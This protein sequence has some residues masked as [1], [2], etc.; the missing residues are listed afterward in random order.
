MYLYVS[1]RESIISIRK[2]GR[3]SSESS[4]SLLPTLRGITGRL[5]STEKNERRF[6]AVAPDA[7]LVEEIINART[8]FSSS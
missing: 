5:L 4:F 7:A 6:A 1:I 3:D 2:F 8:G